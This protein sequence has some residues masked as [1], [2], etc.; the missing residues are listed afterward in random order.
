M[1]LWLTLNMCSSAK[2]GSSWTQIVDVDFPSRAINTVGKNMF[3]VSGSNFDVDSYATMTYCDTGN[4]ARR[5]Q[6]SQFFNLIQFV[7]G[8]G[9][10][11]Q[12]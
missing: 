11:I 2:K 1:L 12:S 10:A 4:S 5:P 7:W 8:G 9:V 6:N 3:K